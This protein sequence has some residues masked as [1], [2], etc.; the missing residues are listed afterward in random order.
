[1]R[2]RRCN[3]YKTQH[4]TCVQRAVWDATRR[5]GC[6]GTPA[7]RRVG[8]EAA[9]SPRA[10]GGHPAQSIGRNA[11]RRRRQPTRKLNAT[12]AAKRATDTAQHAK[13]IT[14]GRTRS[15]ASSCSRLMRRRSAVFSSSICAAQARV[16]AGS[17]LHLA[18]L[19]VPGGPTLAVDAIMLRATTAARFPRR[20][21]PS[22]A[23][24]LALLVD[25]PAHR[26][27]RCALLRLDFLPAS[28]RSAY[29]PSAHAAQCSAAHAR[30]STAQHSVLRM[31]ALPW[32]AVPPTAVKHTRRRSDFTPARSSS[33]AAASTRGSEGRHLQQ[34]L[35]QTLLLA[36]RLRCEAKPRVSEC[37]A[38]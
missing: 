10:A 29:S 11:F 24:L 21:G 23:Y 18:Q 13:I 32:R 20:S 9:A 8:A 6:C 12:N 15:S 5:V 28:K 26:L 38:R 34:Q 1:M 16:P 33:A 17:M 36:F 37:S 14:R 7:L 22:R 30:P 4:A 3:A 2:R 25:G 19:T 35:A 31:L 27:E